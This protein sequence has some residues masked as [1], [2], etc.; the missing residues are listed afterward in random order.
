M[1]VRAILTYRPQPVWI[2][3]ELPCI[4]QFRGMFNR[5]STPDD[6]LGILRI[7]D[8]S[9]ADTV[10]VVD[11]LCTP[12]LLVQQ[13]LDGGLEFLLQNLPAVLRDILD[14]A[15]SDMRFL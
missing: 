5:E 8:L 3:N 15:R 9:L 7:V 6:N 4:N 1:R 14:I 13:R 2:V 10:E 11:G 12:Q